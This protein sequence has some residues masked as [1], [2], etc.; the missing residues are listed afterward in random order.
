M[1]TS[2]GRCAG[3]TDCT[4]RQ[5]NSLSQV[6]VESAFRQLYSS[7]CGTK[8]KVE[9]T[10]LEDDC[11]APTTI[12]E[13]L[14]KPLGLEN[15]TA[16]SILSEQ[17]VLRN[18]DS[19]RATTSICNSESQTARHFA[20]ESNLKLNTFLTKAKENQMS[21]G[22]TLVFTVKQPVSQIEGST[23]QNHDGNEEEN[24]ELSR[25]D[26]DCI[27]TNSGEDYRETVTCEACSNVY[28]KV[29]NRKGTKKKRASHKKPPYDP[30]S[31]SCDQWIL[32]K[33]LLP[34]SPVQRSKRNLRSCKRKVDEFL[35]MHSKRQPQKK[36][37]KRS[38]KKQ[39]FI[40]KLPE[41]PLSST[42]ISDNEISEIEISTVKRKLT[43]AVLTRDDRTKRGSCDFSDNTQSDTLS[44]DYKSVQLENSTC[45]NV[46][47]FTF[48][49]RPLNFVPERIPAFSTTSSLCSETPLH[50]LNEKGRKWVE[51]QSKSNSR[52]SPC[53]FGWLKPSGFTSMVA[54]L[55]ARPLTS[56]GSVIKEK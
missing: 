34:R 9:K 49:F 4:S 36:T 26:Y 17:V 10:A 8:E 51:V 48:D 39:L 18:S 29:M 22:D 12:S 42:V 24:F 31:L 56:S 45:A 11:F 52:A 55:K 16:C 21:N 2:R 50:P 23:L 54:K 15:L 25:E 32:K 28:W 7:L 19:G 1:W 27:S 33:P 14:D 35:A 44:S 3:R 53:S 13:D 40:F 43:S 30:T 37:K 6:E 46:D 20:K 38:K 5:N 41:S 47:M